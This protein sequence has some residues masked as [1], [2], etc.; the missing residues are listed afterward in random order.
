V[1][2]GGAAVPAGGTLSVAASNTVVQPGTGTHTLYL[3]GA[4]DT[5]VVPP[6]G[7]G[8]LDIFGPALAGGNRLDFRQ[9]LSAAG[10]QGS[11][12]TLSQFMQVSA[13]FGA[14]VVSITAKG[15][16]PA[17][18]VRLEGQGGLTLS[19]LVAHALL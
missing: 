19:G 7:R 8:F 16:Q 12:A 13:T 10:W 17:P 1:P 18:V 2:F 15:A 6:A 9:A 4:G 5:I 14:A 3:S 11:L